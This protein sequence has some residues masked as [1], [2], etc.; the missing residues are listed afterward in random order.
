MNRSAI[1]LAVCCLWA[2]GCGSDTATRIETYRSALGQLQATS[3][4]I[5]VRLASIETFLSQAH[6]SLADPN[7][8]SSSAEIREAIETALSKRDQA[9]AAKAKVDLA[10]AQIRTELEAI[11]VEGADWTDEISL[12]GSALAAGGQAAGGEVGAWLAAI[13]GI[14]AGAGGVLRGNRKA[15]DANRTTERIISSVDTL[16][17]SDLVTNTEKAKTLLRTDQGRAISERVKA[18]KQG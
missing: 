14:L 17:T 7:L 18:I 13:G 1:L 3:S 16:L 8:G 12:L 11:D 2:G 9:I 6:A 10:I 4:E 15:S 5:D